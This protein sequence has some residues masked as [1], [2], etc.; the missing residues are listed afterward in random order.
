MNTL[1]ERG[2]SSFIH[3]YLSFVVETGTKHKA[4]RGE[5]ITSGNEEL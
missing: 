5:K 1:G 3:H 4:L 2:N